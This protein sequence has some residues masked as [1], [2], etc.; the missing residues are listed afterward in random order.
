MTD[1]LRAWGG[2]VASFCL[3]K[4][5]NERLPGAFII[6]DMWKHLWLWPTELKGI[7]MISDGCSVS[8]RGMF[9]YKQTDAESIKI[10]RSSLLRKPL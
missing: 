5:R 9:H 4:Q 2:A 7:S 1:H 6:R 8:S 3:T 10:L